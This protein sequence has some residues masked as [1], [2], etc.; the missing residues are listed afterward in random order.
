MF[1]DQTCDTDKTF[2]LKAWEVL[3]EI[4][5]PY[6]QMSFYKSPASLQDVALVLDGYELVCLQKSLAL[7]S[8][9]HFS[10]T[11]KYSTI[12]ICASYR[13]HYHEPMVHYPARFID[14]VKRV[15]FV[16]GGDSMLLHEALKYPS[17]EL[18]VGLEL[19]QAV[20]RASFKYFGTQPH[21]DN[22]KVEWWFGDATK[23][24]LMLPKEYFG[25]FDLVLVDLS[26]TVMAM[27]V[28]GDLDVKQ[29]LSVR[30][31]CALCPLFCNY[32][33]PQLALIV[34]F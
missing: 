3:E 2:N 31:V 27:T 24:L 25:S 11:Y 34:S 14:T 5:S 8:Y 7:G 21:W 4:R 13:P 22:E 18:V 23:S 17:L 16:G 9:P 10:H 20:T 33:I 6:Q 32:L 15:L 12:Q 19:D 30:S 26:E 29:A 28:T 1:L